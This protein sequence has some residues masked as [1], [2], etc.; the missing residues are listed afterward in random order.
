MLFRSLAHTD[1]CHRQSFHYRRKK[2]ANEGRSL[3]D[4]DP[5]ISYVSNGGDGT[6][7]P[8]LSSQRHTVETIGL[9]DIATE[10]NELY[11]I[12]EEVEVD[13]NTD[14]GIYSLAGIYMCISRQPTD[15]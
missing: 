15:V 13:V 4:L 2:K 5:Y 6:R 10:S 9:D 1:I 8:H 12:G 14:E 7:T 11:S 3:N